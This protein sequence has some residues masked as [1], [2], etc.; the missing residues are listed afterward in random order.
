[1]KMFEVSY[2][3]W[4]KCN[5]VESRPLRS[6]R[7]RAAEELSCQRRVKQRKQDHG[8]RSLSS[9]S[10]SLSAT[11]TATTTATASTFTHDS[12][13]V[14]LIRQQQ[15]HRALQYC[16]SFPY[17]SASTMNGTNALSYIATQSE[18]PLA[19]LCACPMRAK[20]KEAII[21]LVNALLNATPWSTRW[22]PRADTRDTLLHIALTNITCFPEIVTILFKDASIS[23]SS[24]P[25]YLMS[26]S[27][28]GQGITEP[29]ILQRNQHGLTAIDLLLKRI[30]RAEPW[31]KQTCA[32]LTMLE[33]VLGTIVRYNKIKGNNDRNNSGSTTLIDHNPTQSKL[34][35][36]PL[37]VRLFTLARQRSHASER[38]SSLQLKHLRHAV[39]VILQLVPI[40][41]ADTDSE[42][43]GSF[44]Y[45]TCSVVTGCTPLHAAFYYLPQEILVHVDLLL[46]LQA[47]NWLLRLNF[48]GELP[49]HAACVA[50][51]KG[52]VTV[53]CSTSFVYN[54]VCIAAVHLHLAASLSSY[55]S[56]R[57][58]FKQDFRC[59]VCG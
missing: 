31:D 47:S 21:P 4:V 7:I 9:S 44:V 41:A 34:L 12:P 6:S 39:R 49:L 35:Q 10:T 57:F 51:G 26:T 27:R 50:Q 11:I 33:D 17:E 16:T 19:I 56:S 30:V 37:L 8:V 46:S 45:H 52:H 25:Y 28:N 42:R 15:W 53:Q 24:L 48:Y 20:D 32:Y 59:F 18:S 36:E 22:K 58:C 14:A 23:L 5:E 2:P 43:G 3:T 38:L 40:S 13:L 54:H 1:M 55:H 29:G